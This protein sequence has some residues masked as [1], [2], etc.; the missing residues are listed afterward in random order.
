[1]Q[2]HRFFPKAIVGTSRDRRGEVMSEDRNACLLVRSLIIAGMAKRHAD[3]ISIILNYDIMTIPKLL[4][5]TGLQE[6]P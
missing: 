3:S 2:R 5:P 6:I 1:M 4:I